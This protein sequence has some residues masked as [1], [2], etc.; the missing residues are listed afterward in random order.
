MTFP[1]ALTEVLTGYNIATRTAWHGEIFI[2][3]EK[4]DRTA[5]ESDHPLA[6]AYP[7][8]TMLP[9]HAYVAMKGHNGSMP[10]TPGQLDMFADDWSIV[11][12]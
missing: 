5:I 8:N 7:E 3:L 2:Y 11:S 10:W 1:E 6:D 9:Y 12:V 4:A